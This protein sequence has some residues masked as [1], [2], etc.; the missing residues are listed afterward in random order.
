MVAISPVAVAKGGEHRD[1]QKRQ[2]DQIGARAAV[3]PDDQSDGED[4]EDDLL[5]PGEFEDAGEA[6]QKDA[7][8]ES[9]EPKSFEE[10]IV[11]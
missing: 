9:E 6:E 11:T 3:Q 4:A 7:A 10:E 2:R 5:G 1:Q 8:N